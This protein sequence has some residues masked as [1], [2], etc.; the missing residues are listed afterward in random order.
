VETTK[1]DEKQIKKGQKKV[2][3][4]LDID[5]HEYFETGFKSKLLPVHKLM[6]HN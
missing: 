1:E 6:L 5:R 4:S 3:A 2:K